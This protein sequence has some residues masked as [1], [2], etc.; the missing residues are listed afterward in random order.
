L[1]VA[2]FM[3]SAS[4]EREWLAAAGVPP[5]QDGRMDNKS[6]PGRPQGGVSDS[7]REQALERLRAAA[8]EGGLTFQEL[9]E[10]TGRVHAADTPREVEAVTGDLPAT[11]SRP[12]PASPAKQWLVGV[13]SNERLTGRWTAPPR[14][15]AVA[16]LG[17]VII[18]LRDA[19]VRGEQL[20]IQ[21]TALVGDV[22]VLIP[23]GATV[24]MS[25]VAV[26]G[27]K[28]FAVEPPEYTLAVPVVRV[29]AVAILGDVIVATQPPKSRIK[30]ARARWKNRKSE[31]SI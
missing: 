11:P 25:G 5:R 31:D 27:H 22:Y 10:R 4:G 2:E 7:E 14:L 16:V 23:P 26:L 19:K 12:V 30:S 6:E 17:D 13:L 3:G 9:A 1:P 20:S 24:Q 18:D 29:S 15:T 21:A 28:K 8:A